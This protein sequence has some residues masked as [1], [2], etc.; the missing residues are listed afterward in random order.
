[1][2]R[3]LFIGDEKIRE[4]IWELVTPGVED[5]ESEETDGEARHKRKHGKKKKA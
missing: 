1:M 4:F 3:R 2:R 5:E